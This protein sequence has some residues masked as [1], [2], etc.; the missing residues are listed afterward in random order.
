MEPFDNK[1]VL[2]YELVES[3]KIVIKYQNVQLEKKMKE[4]TKK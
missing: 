1:L 2:P 4:L 3:L